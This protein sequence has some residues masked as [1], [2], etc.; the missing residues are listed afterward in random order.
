MLGLLWAALLL[1]VNIMP[2][3][4]SF[5]ISKSLT[6]SKSF[7][8]LMTW[9]FDTSTSIAFPQSNTV[10]FDSNTV[11]YVSQIGISN[12]DGSNINRYSTILGW[13]N[14]ANSAGTKYLTVGSTVFTI[15]SANYVTFN[16]RF[17]GSYYSGPTTLPSSGQNLSIS[18]TY[19][20]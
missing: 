16:F 15:T 18:F 19:I 13:H 9:A 6:V 1:L 11:I 5:T 4:G 10:R 12:V 20:P 2:R 17:L 8:K 7:R 14:Q 3:V